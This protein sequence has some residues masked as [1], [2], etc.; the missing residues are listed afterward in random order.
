MPLTLTWRDATTLPVDG[1]M[2]SPGRLCPL[3]LLG[4][5]QLPTRVGRTPATLGDL[6]AIEGDGGDGHLILEGGLGHVVEIGRGM[7]S[8]SLVVRGDAGALVGA[9]MVGGSISVEGSVGDWAAAEMRG[10]LIRVTGD[11]GESL[12]A[13]L[14][15]SRLGMRDGTVLV[16]GTVGPDAGLRMRRGLIAVG[17][18]AGPGLGRAMVAGSIF[19]FGPVGPRPGAGMKRGTIA[20][21]GPVAGTVSLLPTFAASGRSRPP[22]LAIYLK[23]LDDR[24]FPVP[25]DAYAVTPARY[26][27]D[28]AEGGQ[29]EV[30][31][32]G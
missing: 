19:A 12:A 26:N 9:A 16:H 17:G 5:A 15:G 27:G 14:P 32:A 18:G 21:L 20:L 31:V 28:L 11:A 22:F 24:R 7:E 23:F 6:F 2:L 13:A 10:G 30:L 1:A 4:V 25:S 3:D 8:G 29:G